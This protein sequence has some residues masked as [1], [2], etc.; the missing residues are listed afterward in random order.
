V[1][2]PASQRVGSLYDLGRPAPPL[3]SASSE[4]RS[5]ERRSR[6]GGTSG[7]RRNA[8]RALRQFEKRNAGVPSRAGAVSPLTQRRTPMPTLIHTSD[9]QTRAGA[10]IVRHTPELRFSARQAEAPQP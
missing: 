6:C 9:R 5:R 2:F 10:V 1:R 4:R 7:L 3:R 8:A